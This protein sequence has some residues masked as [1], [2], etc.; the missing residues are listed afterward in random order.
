MQWKT[1]QGPRQGP[2]TQAGKVA[3]PWQILAEGL[4]PPREGRHSALHWGSVTPWPQFV[5][6][7]KECFWKRK[8]NDYR[9]HKKDDF[10]S[11][12]DNRIESWLNHDF[13]FIR[14]LPKSM[15]TDELVQKN[16]SAVLHQ[17]NLNQSAYYV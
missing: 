6:F 12:R 13:S 2:L 14:L 1:R 16:Q 4:N 3:N 11:Y 15:K 10:T 5:L 9:L 7:S 17:F 8:L